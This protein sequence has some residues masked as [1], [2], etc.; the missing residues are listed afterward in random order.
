MEMEN[1]YPGRVS[2]RRVSAHS[3]EGRSYGKIEGGHHIA[4]VYNVL[5][6]HDEIE[7]LMKEIDELKKNE[8]KNESVIAEK[9]QAI[10]EALKP[11]KEKA[12]EKGYLMT[13]VL[14]VNGKVKSMD[15]VPGKEK[16]KEWIDA[17]LG[18][19]D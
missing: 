12:K 14:V 13:P 11:V 7:S 6:N 9:F 15:Y 17:E 10:D 2:V 3:D 18:I 16:I 8:Q 19:N 1:I 5:H 4:E